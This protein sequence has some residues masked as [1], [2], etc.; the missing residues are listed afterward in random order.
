MTTIFDFMRYTGTDFVLEIRH[1][2][3]IGDAM[4]RR[5]KAGRLL[6]AGKGCAEAA[7]S[8]GMA[9]QTVYT[10]KLFS[11]KRAL[12]HCETWVGVAPCAIG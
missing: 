2:K 4:R 5:V 10:W 6:L 11:M 7:K 12:T 3:K 9:R 8:V 1:G